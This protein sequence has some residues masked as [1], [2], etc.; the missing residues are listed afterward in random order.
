MLKVTVKQPH[1]GETYFIS[2]GH[3]DLEMQSG[4]D[5]LVI[6]HEDRWGPRYPVDYYFEPGSEVFLKVI[7]HRP[8][9]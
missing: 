2:E 8:I 3:G 9:P 7:G 1:L 4:K 6:T 5:G